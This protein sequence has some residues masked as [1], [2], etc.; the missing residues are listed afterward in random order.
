[1]KGFVPVFRKELYGMFMSPIFYVVAFFFLLVSGVFFNYI[2]SQVVMASFQLAQHPELGR[3]QHDGVVPALLP[4]E[5]G[6][7]Y[8]FCRSSFNN[9]ALR[10]RAQKRHNR[11]DCTLTR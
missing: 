4:V 7:R 6:C 5:P 2:L 3:F 9:E 10:R 8:A 1:M 11:T